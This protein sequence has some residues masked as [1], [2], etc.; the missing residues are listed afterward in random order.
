MSNS[1]EQRVHRSSVVDELMKQPVNQ[2]PPAV[3]SI[4]ISH[5][6]DALGSQSKAPLTDVNDQLTEMMNRVMQALPAH[7]RSE[8]LNK[9]SGAFRLAY[10][11]GQLS[12]AN[13]FASTT[14][15][16]MPDE[17][18]YAVFK[19]EAFTSHFVILTAGPATVKEV[20]WQCKVP[21]EEA[22]KA[23]SKFAELGIIDFRRRLG[24]ENVNEYFLTPA[25]R[26]MLKLHGF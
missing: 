5:I 14:L 4:M 16:H 19:D 1:T 26:Q 21:E 15:A 7:A 12:F 2:W 3:I 9:D 24:P 23:L 11:L 22:K 18:F 13:E 25:A 8:I 10:L 6:A 17:E 20:A